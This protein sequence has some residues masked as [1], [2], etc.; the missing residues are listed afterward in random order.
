MAKIGIFICHCGENIT[1]T[2]DVE[3]VVEEAENF[4]GVVFA[5]DY[6][7]VCSEPGQDLI[8]ETIKEEGLTGVVVAACSPRMHEPTFRKA[9]ATAGL[10]P[11]LCEMANIREHCSWVH[12]DAE[13][14]T[15]KAIDMVRIMAE[16]VKR[17][18]ELEPI[19]VPVT[20]PALA[21]GGGIAGI[22]ASLDTANRGHDVVLVEQTPPI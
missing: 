17:N 12:P 16:K 3:E 21:T 5:K 20:K 4:K 22:Q 19:L 8:K 7:Y 11:Y 13:E 14:T 6:K 9:C 18:I 15:Q 2:V 1:R 10:N